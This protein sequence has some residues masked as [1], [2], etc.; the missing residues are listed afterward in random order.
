MATPQYYNIL[1]QILQTYR[2]LWDF[3]ALLLYR[4]VVEHWI[5]E[6]DNFTI[7]LTDLWKSHFAKYIC[8]LW[9]SWHCDQESGKMD[10]Q[11]N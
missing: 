7:Y 9:L 8:I 3:V 10:E 11:V 2:A 5:V 6:T 4:D 1:G